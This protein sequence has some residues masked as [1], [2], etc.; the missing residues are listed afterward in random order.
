MLTSRARGRAENRQYLYIGD[1]HLSSC[2]NTELARGKMW[3]VCKAM[4]WELTVGRPEAVALV[5]HVVAFAPLRMPEAWRITGAVNDPTS[6]APAVVVIDCW[7]TPAGPSNGMVY[8]FNGG[9]GHFVPR[10]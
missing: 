8:H 5:V 4:Q 1:V 2:S 3:L 6:A 9:H 10:R 7:Q